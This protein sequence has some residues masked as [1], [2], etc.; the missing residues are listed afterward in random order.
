MLLLP[1]GRE[2][3][4]HGPCGAQHSAWNGTRMS[5][6]C[7]KSRILILLCTAELSSSAV[8]PL[9]RITVSLFAE[10]RTP[11]KDV[12]VGR[13][14]ITCV[15]RHGSSISQHY[16]SCASLSI[17]RLEH[18]IVFSSAEGHTTEPIT[19][20]LTVTVSANASS[21]PSAPVNTQDHTTVIDDPLAEGGAAS[22]IVQSINETTQPE[23]DTAPLFPSSGTGGVPIG[24]DAPVR[25]R[26]E[27]QTKMSRTLDSAEEAMGAIKTWK[28]AVDVVK[29]VM[30]HVGPVVKVCLTSFFPILL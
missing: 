13:Q 16:Y 19:L 18:D 26:A 20:S 1:T 4:G 10:K 28:S 14:Q 22:R 12:L 7:A 25:P 8:Q 6:N 2:L 24:A 27:S 21:L 30:D 3:G 15:P 23:A 17:V 29:Q 9:S 11:K 5:T